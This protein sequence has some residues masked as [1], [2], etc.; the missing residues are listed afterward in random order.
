M[1]SEQNDQNH[2]TIQPQYLAE[3][4]YDAEHIGGISYLFELFYLLQILM[5][6]NSTTTV[7][8]FGTRMRLTISE[9]ETANKSTSG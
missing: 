9:P 2:L 3:P 1:A 8:S 5:N 7:Q 6:I 4:Q